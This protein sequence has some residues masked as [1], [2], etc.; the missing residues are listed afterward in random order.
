[1]YLI[2]EVLQW[3]WIGPGMRVCRKEGIMKK[4]NA[5]LENFLEISGT[6]H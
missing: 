1:M 3:V 6:L 2:Y 5:L 4:T